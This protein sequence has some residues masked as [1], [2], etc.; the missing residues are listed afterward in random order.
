MLYWNYRVVGSNQ[1]CN[2][3][4]DTVWI[5]KADFVFISKPKISGDQAAAFI[6]KLGFTQVHSVDAH[7]VAGGIWV[8]LVNSMY[9]VQL[10]NWNTYFIHLKIISSRIQPML[11]TVVHTNPKVH[12]KS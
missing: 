10:L 12:Q 8:M 9:N 5:N 3:L 6:A 11:C 4:K 2:I 1:F 7:G